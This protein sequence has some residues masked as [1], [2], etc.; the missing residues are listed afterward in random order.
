MLKSFNRESALRTA[1]NL[2]RL[3]AG[4]E[5]VERLEWQQEKLREDYGIEIDCRNGTARYIENKQS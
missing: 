2:A 3:V 4:G 5:K 1:Q